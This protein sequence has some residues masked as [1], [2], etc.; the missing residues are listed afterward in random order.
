MKGKWSDDTLE[1]EWSDFSEC[2]QTCGGGTQ[3]R[4][5][6]NPAP[7]DEDGDKDEDGGEGCVGDAT[8][9]CNVHPCSG[10]YCRWQWGDEDE[11][12]MRVRG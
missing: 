11:G 1:G 9:L 4:T 7:E 10:I 2:S 6:N 8:Q 5:C 3:S 12:G